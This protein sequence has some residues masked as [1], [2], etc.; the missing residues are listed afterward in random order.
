MPWQFLTAN[1]YALFLKLRFCLTQF[2]TENRYALFLE[3]L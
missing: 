3:L 2:L 1:R